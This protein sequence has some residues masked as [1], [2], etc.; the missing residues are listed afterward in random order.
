MEPTSAI[1]TSLDSKIR[2]KEGTGEKYPSHP[3]CEVMARCTASARAIGRATY[4]A[5]DGN[6]IFLFD[7]GNG[8]FTAAFANKVCSK[9]GAIPD[10]SNDLPTLIFTVLTSD[11]IPSRWGLKDFSCRSATDFTVNGYVAIG[12]VLNDICQRSESTAFAGIVGFKDGTISNIAD[13]YSSI[14]LRAI[15]AGNF[16]TVRNIRQ[17]Q[18]II[19]RRTIV[20]RAADLCAA[21]PS[22]RNYRTN[23]RKA[24]AILGVL[25][26]YSVLGE[27]IGFGQCFRKRNNNPR[28][29]SA[30]T[31]FSFAGNRFSGGCDNDVGR[32]GP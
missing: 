21:I 26:H 11:F 4:F 24:A 9:D 28:T 25:D 6:R 32:G 3:G 7:I 23:R 30:T 27:A 12:H 5:F 2:D 17:R 29:S 20:V 10:I 14:L 13:N 19:S 15:V 18:A 1:A 16:V 31:D 8:G 22:G